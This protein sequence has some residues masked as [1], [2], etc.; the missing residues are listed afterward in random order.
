V[1]WHGQSRCQINTYS[2]RVQASGA[3][4]CCQLLLLTSKS[5]H[6]CMEGSKSAGDRCWDGSSS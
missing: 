4:H 3:A 2:W 1:Q 6:R 5:E